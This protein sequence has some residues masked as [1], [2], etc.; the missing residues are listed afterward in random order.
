MKKKV[1]VQIEKGMCVNVYSELS[2]LD[3]TVLDMD[4]VDLD[5]KERNEAEEAELNEAVLRGDLHRY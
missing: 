1:I 4:S 5:D 2:D 3:V